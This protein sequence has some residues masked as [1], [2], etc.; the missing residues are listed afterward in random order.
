[1]SF[2]RPTPQQAREWAVIRYAVFIGVCA[3]AVLF[4]GPSLFAGRA[5]PPLSPVGIAQTAV[6][7]AVGAAFAAHAY[8]YLDPDGES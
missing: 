6:A 3:A 2:D 7:F 1:M 5:F 8:V 4:F